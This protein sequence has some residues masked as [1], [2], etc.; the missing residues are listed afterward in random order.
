M[1]DKYPN[2]RAFEDLRQQTQGQVTY[3]PDSVDAADLYSE[4]FGFRQQF[5]SY[6]SLM[7]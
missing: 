7:E 5:R 1:T 4:L 2:L 3:K 6:Y